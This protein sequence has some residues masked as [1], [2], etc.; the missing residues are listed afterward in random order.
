MP[1][2]SGFEQVPH[3]IFAEDEQLVKTYCP[4]EQFE[5]VWHVV[6]V[7][8]PTPVEYV[9]AWQVTHA[10]MEL[11]AVPVKYVPATQKMQGV[12]VLVEYLPAEQAPQV[13]A[14]LCPVP[15]EYVPA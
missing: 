1:F 4:V 11:C 5:H 2:V 13:D 6:G 15:V 14:R 3:V 9:P 12:V 7:V 10:V 8:A